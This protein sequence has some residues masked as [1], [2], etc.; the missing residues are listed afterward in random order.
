MKGTKLAKC[1]YL[2]TLD[3]LKLELYNWKTMIKTLSWGKIV[4]YRIDSS[5]MLYNQLINTTSFSCRSARW[6]LHHL[7]S[8][9]YCKGGDFIILELQKKTSA[10]SKVMPETPAKLLDCELPE[11]ATAIGSPAC[12]RFISLML[13]GEPLQNW[14]SRNMK[15]T[16]FK[17]SDGIS[18]HISC[19]SI[20]ILSESQLNV[21]LLV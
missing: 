17:I 5:S 18:I 21:F 12:D 1:S 14:R 2:T 7:I 16:W 3:G 4:P 19:I 11:S 6:Y 8:N 20:Q 13:R 15:H 10:P 9:W